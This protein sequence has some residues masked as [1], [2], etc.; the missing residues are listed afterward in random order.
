MT[1]IYIPLKDL[2]LDAN[3]NTG[4]RQRL[5]IKGDEYYV[6]SVVYDSQA[7]YIALCTS[8]GPEREGETF[9]VHI[10]KL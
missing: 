1:M 6:H 2:W 5:K 7:G 3:P 9:Q 10:P 8:H 4:Q